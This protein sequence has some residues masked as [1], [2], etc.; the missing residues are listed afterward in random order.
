MC[1]FKTNSLLIVFTTINIEEMQN[2]TKLC[3][4]E[5]TLKVSPRG[6]E[7]LPNLRLIRPSEASLSPG[8]A[9]MCLIKVTL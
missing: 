5:S 2:H 1:Y 6:K 3:N 8:S 4:S 7:S 9:R